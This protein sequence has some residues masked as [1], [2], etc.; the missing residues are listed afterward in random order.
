M[1]EI[2]TE[3]YKFILHIIE[4][5]NYVNILSIIVVSFS[6]YQVAKFNASKPEKIRVKQMQL[7]NVYLPLFRLYADIPKNL[8]KIQALQIHKKTANILN[9]NYELAFPQLHR[10]TK[11]LKKEILSDKDFNKTIGIIKHQ[12]STDYELL[13]KSLGYP[14][15]NLVGIIIRMT[16]SQ[17]IEAVKIWFNILILYAPMVIL[18]L[19]AQNDH[20]MIGMILGAAFL[21][22]TLIFSI[23][24]IICIIKHMDD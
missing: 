4:N 22:F 19:A 5:E 13:K 10:L 23:F 21:V 24:A 12:V 20:N 3:I 17:K 6:S 14:S 16:F 8:S 11:R 1:K 2:F 7:S 15:E 18:Y 9:S